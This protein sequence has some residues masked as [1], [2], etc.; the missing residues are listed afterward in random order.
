MISRLKLWVVFGFMSS[1]SIVGAASGGFSSSNAVAVGGELRV[2]DNYRTEYQYL[3]GWS[4]AGERLE[5]GAQ[6]MHEV[7][8]SPGAVVAYRNTGDFPDGTVLVKEVYTASTTTMT[9]GLVSRVND[10]KGWFIMV[11]DSKNS[12]PDNKLWGDGW[13]WSWFDVNKPTR[14]TSTDY[15]IDCQ[16]CHIPAKKSHLIYVEGY[17]QLR[18]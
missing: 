15:S 4:V 7:Y 6:Q 5:Q 17:P 2:P 13:G 14:T 12:H 16:G 3:G 1:A 10:L 8:I 9:T 18:R 11:R